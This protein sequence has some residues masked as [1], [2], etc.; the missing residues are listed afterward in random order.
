MPG[1][2]RRSSSL[3]SSSSDEPDWTRELAIVSDEEYASNF[4]DGYSEKPL[5]EQLEPIAVVGM[6]CRLP[7]NVSSPAQFW[8]MMMNKRSGRTPKVPASRFN[9]DAHLHPNNERPGSFNVP[10]GYF[11][12]S[13]LQEFDPALF[14]ISPIE[15][16]WMDPQQRKL[17]E[18]VYE[19]LESG[20]ITLNQIENTKTAVFV[21]SFTSDFQQMSFKE[22]DFRHSYAATGVDPGI[23]SNRISHVFNLSGPSITVNTACSSSIYAMHNAC[24]AL[25]NKECAGALVGGT[26]LILTVD[27]H[28]NT[29][30][31]GV[32]SPDSTCHTFDAS[33]NGYGRADGVG[34]VYLKRLSDAL[35][36]GDPIRGVL[37][38]SAVNSNGKVPNVGITYP[39]REGQA[40]VIR[41]AYQRGGDLDPRFT[42]YFEVHGTGTP[43]G[44]PIE[45]HAVSQAMNKE[46]TLRTTDPYTDSLWIGAVKTNIGHSEAASGLSA[47]IKAVLTVENG[48]IPPTRGLVNPNPAIDWQN[49]NIKVPS[50][51]QPFPAHLPVRRVSVNSF[52]YG[53]TNGHFIVESV[54]SLVPG[55]SHGQKRAKRGD[56]GVFNQRRPYL[57]PFSAHDKPTLLRNIEAYSKVVDDYNLLDLSYTLSNR[58]SK[59]ASRG[60]AVCSP[61]N[62][63]K[64]FGNI[65]ENFIFADKKK[66]PVVGFAFTGQGAQWA[67][68]GTELMLYYPSFLR[69]IRRLDK[70]LGDLHS[71][72][73]WTLEDELQENAPTSRINE[74]EF[75]QPLC[76]AV[77]V[78]LVDL[79][80]SWGVIPSVTVGHSSG[81]IAAAYAAGLIGFNESIIAAYFRGKVVKDINT[82]GAMMAVGLGAEAV[83]PYLAGYERQVVVACHNS[84]ALVTLSG[85]ADALD[86]VKNRLDAEKVFA[87]IVKTGG[88]AYHSFHMKPAASIYHELMQEARSQVVASERKA[89][90]AIM[91]S[92]VTNTLLDPTQPLDADY[93]CANLISP[94]KFNQ[95]VQTIG[96]HPSFKAVDLLIEIGPHSALKGPILQICREHKLDRLNYLPTIERNGNSATQLLSLAGQL[97]LRNYDLKYER[98]AAIEQMSFSGK[99]Q[100]KTGKLLV[101]LPTYQWT[102]SKDLWAEPRQSAE[103]RAPKH[104][105]HDTLGSRLPGGSKTSPTWRNCLR[106]LDLPWLKHHSLGG[107]AIF[108]AAGYFSM[109]IEAITQMNEDGPNPVEINGYTLRDVSIKAALVIPDDNDGIETLFTIQPS[110]YTDAG[111]LVWWDFN[112]AS[113][114]QAG[115][116]NAHMT[117]TI[118]INSRPRQEPREVPSFNQRATGKSWNDALKG[119]GFDYG[120]SFQDMQDIRS[121]G[122]RFHAAASSVIKKESGMVQGESRYVLHPATIDSCLQL[123]IVSIYAGNIQKM[124]CG[125]V[126]IQVDEVSIWPPTQ[127][128]MENP[129]AQAYSWTDERGIR[130]FNSGT[131]LVGSDGRLV[132]SINEMRCVAYEAA[133]PQ[134]R[135]VTIR[136]QPFMKVD[137]NIDIDTLTAKSPVADLS[138]KD[139]VVLSAFKN[140]GI[141]VLDIGTIEPTSIP[142]ATEFIAYTATAAT[143]SGVEELSQV[144]STLEHATALKVDPALELETQ[145]LK[146]GQFDLVLAGDLKDASKLHWLLSPGGLVITTR[147]IGACLSERFSVLNL[148]NGL[149]IATAKQ[150]QKTEATNGHSNGS[151]RSIAIVYRHALTDTCRNIANVVDGLGVPRFTAL[152]NA[153]FLPSEHVIITCDL[154]GPL[155]LTLEADELSGLKSMVSNATSVTWISKGGL[156]KGGMP[157]QAM[158]S[159]LARSVASEN[160]SLDFTTI[161]VD[162]STNT[163]AQAVNE[164]AKALERQIT[165]AKSKE[166]EYCV[167]KGLVYISRLV[168]DETLNHQYGP[169][170]SAAKSAPFS[171]SGKLVALPTNSKLTFTHDDRADKVVGANEVQIQVSL[172]SLNKEDVLVREGTD[173]PTTFSHEIYGVVT[174]KG[175]NVKHVNLGD[176]AFGFSCDRLAS[177]QTVSADLVEKAVASDKPEE[178]VTLPM[179]YATALHGLRTLA[180][181]EAGEIVLILHGSGHPGAAAISLSKAL[182]AKTYVAVRSTSEA[183]RIAAVFELPPNHVIPALDHNVMARLKEQTEGRE[184]DIVF[185]S[186]Y[187]PTSV[188]HGCWRTIASFGRFIE[189]GRKNVLTRSALD[190]V[191]THRGASYMAFDILDLYSQKPRLL[192][193][194]LRE[195]VALYRQKLIPAIGPI[196]TA[197]I[198]DFDGA[199][200]SFTDDFAGKKTVI[201]HVES[202]K[203]IEVLP[204]RAELKFRPDATYFLVGCLGGLGRSIT[205]WMAQHGAKRFALMGRSGVS[206]EQTASWIRSIESTGVTCQIIKGDAAKKGDVEAA[207][208]LIPASHPVR[209]VVH[210]A[211]VL[212]DGMFHS[213][214]YDSWTTSIAPKVHGAIN[215]HQALADTDLDF[216]VLTSSTSGILGTPGQANYAAGN[217]FLDC[218]AKHRVARGQ[219]ASSLVLPMVQSVGVVAENPEI[220]AALRRKGIYGID[221]THLLEA[222]EA[223]IATQATATPADHLI[224]GMDPSKLKESLSSTDVTDSFW[225]EDT[226][227]KT[228]LSAINSTETSGT[229]G[230]GFTI[231]KAIHEA[232]SVQDAIALVSDHFTTKL[233]RLLLVD[234]DVFEPEVL[235]IADYGLDSMIGAELRNWI[236]KEYAFDIPFQKLNGPLTI[237]KFAEL[238]VANQGLTL[239]E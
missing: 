81:E 182:K 208:R 234:I 63:T 72:P 76:T 6:G 75:S 178:V 166:S 188:S 115:Q 86:E 112:V 143:D 113:C 217:A 207:L 216:F 155:L 93:W 141:K 148:V 4:Q 185:S 125:A 52:G 71:G 77:Q 99:E 231:L 150:E 171:R 186:S 189:I 131:Q 114:S 101:N 3:A 100:F 22:P 40:Q 33:A 58:R 117:G 144:F 27:Q 173:Y 233:S 154:E 196:E 70:V 211:M 34:A 203:L 21:G 220:E 227:F 51:P 106:M 104:P 38:S 105:R 214:S 121:D 140:P 48:I 219:C 229:A 96:S 134:K 238:V 120:P 239:S 221:E 60:F 45:V 84:P 29:A 31:L 160:A 118:G 43:V 179:A 133:V 191:P 135:G 175:S 232:N 50:D 127:A 129:Q 169:Q 190:T 236:F 226:R 122:K 49:W 14:N 151:T 158:A 39:N 44:D 183:A 42:G 132:L 107:E 116:W 36:D 46:G 108:P 87:R 237:A 7:G 91:V 47:I 73:D 123:I 198:A 95:A 12:D 193:A 145:G 16:M 224:V 138:V 57:L 128:Q 37:R 215:L 64:A 41:H 85:D 62:V 126:P 149:S 206:N 24:N 23:I 83:Q 110:V 142:E 159:G 230:A 170:S 88:K 103:H 78:A 156:R 172:T 92:S 137:W 94:V 61:D 26:N 35:R 10:G 56:R 176:N 197:N 209:G 180:R 168:A 97:F 200:A 223:S 184:A 174:Q 162:L 195:I 153:Q 157:A 225:T 17:L 1:L 177:F 109:A 167:E 20:G 213:M 69:T 119:V 136:E 228:I 218:L 130:S 54:D 89:T 65:A 201:E 68:M 67:R 204:R 98:V 152:S 66:A 55:Y 8:E 147:E 74:A 18:V 13:S 187:V 15:A 79:L 222:F 80:Q 194:Y 146:Q 53:G 181:V 210:A 139:L 90:K 161:D 19:A 25:R 199:V 11:L 9:I 102:Y 164:V 30:K 111:G 82:N 124:T 5:N 28:M 163:V 202:D 212:R 32:L 2:T 59:L 235:P 165:H 205:A 192:A